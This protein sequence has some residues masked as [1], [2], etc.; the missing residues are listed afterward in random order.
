L[1]E[2]WEPES[3]VLTKMKDLVDILVDRNIDFQIT[4][5]DGFY[6][7]KILEKTLIVEEFAEMVANEANFWQQIYFDYFEFE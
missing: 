5:R 6:S 4:Y 1:L 7:F 2:D 3:E